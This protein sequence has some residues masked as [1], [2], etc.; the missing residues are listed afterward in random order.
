[1]SPNK[2]ILDTHGDP[3]LSARKAA[4]RLRCASDYVSKL[5][6]EGKLDG[7]LVDGQWFVAPASIKAFEEARIRAKQERSQQLAEQRRKENFEYKK[8]YG[9]FGTRTLLRARA[10]A[11]SAPIG[12]IAGGAM[13][14]GAVVFASTMHTPAH[15]QLASVSSAESAFFGTQPPAVHVSGAAFENAS[16]FLRGTF[17]TLFGSS[18]NNTIELAQNSSPSQRG[19]LSADNSPMSGAVAPANVSTGLNSASAP[20]VQNI[21]NTYPVIQRTVV[22]QVASAGVSED[23]VTLRLQDLYNR[24]AVQ[25]S[26]LQ[27]P[28]RESPLQNFAVSQVIN[29]LS[30]VRLNGLSTADDIN[31]HTIN[32]GSLSI[33]GDASFGGTNN[34]NTV[35][36]A[37][38]LTAATTTTGALTVNGNATTTG[39]AYFQNDVNIGGNTVI[40]G[41]LTVLNN[42][43]NPGTAFAGTTTVTNLGVTNL[44]TSTFAGSLQTGGALAVGGNQ[45]SGFKLSVNGLAYIGDPAAPYPGLVPGDEM[46]AQLV[47]RRDANPATMVLRNMN[48]LTDAADIISFANSSD[49][50]DGKLQLNGVAATSLSGS[51][52]FNIMSNFGDIGFWRNY[53]GAGTPTNSLTIKGASAGT[54][55]GFVGIGTQSPQA[56]LDVRD[57]IFVRNTDGLVG[58]NDGVEI[59]TD[60]SVPRISIV[61][62]NR[63]VGLFGGTASGDVLVQNSA[64]GSTIFKGGSGG[65]VE[66]AR[67]TNDGNFGLGT[68]NPNYKLSI[69][70]GSAPGASFPT[71]GFGFVL[72][73][74]GFANAN[75]RFASVEG[76]KA[77]YFL[78]RDTGVSTG[79]LSTYDYGAGV[80]MP[81]LLNANGGNVSIGSATVAQS[82]LDVFGSLALGSYAGVNAAPTNG[83]IVSG[84]VG[85]GTTTPATTFAV[86]GNGL[87][88]GTFTAGSIIATSSFTL[89]GSG[90]INGGFAAYASSTIGNGNQN[91]GLTIFGG[92]TTTGN[93]LFTGGVGIG[94][95]TSAAGTLQVAN[96]AYFGGNLFVGGNSTTIGNST[97]N[98]LVI[99]SSIKSDLVPDQNITRDLGSPSFYWRNVYV[100][101]IVANNISAAS[102]TISGTNSATFTINAD[103]VTSDTE[104][105]DLIFFRGN[106]VPN[107]LLSW[108][109]T[110]KRFEFN[111]P[112]FIQNNTNNTLGNTTLDLKGETGQTGAL[113]NVASSTGTSYFNIANTG[114]TTLAQGFISQASST[115]NGSL[116]V[117]GSAITNGTI[118]ASNIIATSTLTVNGLAIFSNGISLTSSTTIGN[119]NQNG[120]LTIFGGATTT[121]N[122]LFSGALTAAGNSL[123][124]NATSTNFFS[125]T[126]SSTNLF[127]ANASFGTAAAQYLTTTAGA[128]IDNYITLGKNIFGAGGHGDFDGG[129]RFNDTGTNIPRGI[130]SASNG[131]AMAIGINGNNFGSQ[132]LSNQ[133]VQMYFD[134]RGPY[135]RF[136]VYTYEAGTGA[137]NAPISLSSVNTLNIGDGAPTNSQ[138]A[139]LY[140]KDNTSLASVPTFRIDQNGNGTS[141]LMQWFTSGGVQLGAIKAN[142]NLGIGTSTA[143]QA[144]SVQGNGLFSGNISAAAITATSTLNVTG[145]SSFFNGILATASSTIGNGNQ[146]GGLTINGGATTTGSAY[147]AS[148]VGI[149]TANPGYTLD[150]NGSFHANSMFLTGGGNSLSFGTSNANARITGDNA[151]SA[152]YLDFY[153]EGFSR[154]HISDNGNVGIGTTTPSQLFAV[155][156]NQYTSGTAFFGGAITA[157]STLN[158]TGLS[159][160]GSLS[161]TGN[162]TLANATSTNFFSTVASSTNLFAQTGSIGTL[163]AQALTVSGNTT[164]T[165]TL[166]Q[167]GLATFTNGFVS[168]ASST[169]S[170]GL[171][172]ANGGAS[173]TVLSASGSAYFATSG[174]NVG[175]GQ[176]SPKEKL[177][178]NGAGIFSGD[179]ATGINAENYAAAVLIST[180]SGA[181]TGRISAASNGANNVDLELRALNAGSSNSGQLYL[182]SNGNVGIGT[183]S[184]FYKLSV[185]GS[186]TLGNQAIAGFFNATSTTATSTFSGGLTVGG[187]NFNVTPNGNVG[188]GAATDGSFPFEVSNAGGSFAQ[189]TRSS[190]G[191][192]ILGM[193]GSFGASAGSYHDNGDFQIAGSGTVAGQGLIIQTRNTGNSLINALYLNGSGAVGIGTTTTNVSQSG[194][195]TVNANPSTYLPNAFVVSSTTAAGVTSN[196][197]NVLANGTVGVGTSSPATTL[198]VQG[199]GYFTGNVG[200][201]LSSPTALLEVAGNANSS[202]FRVSRIGNASSYFSIAA[203]GG[204]NNA[205][206]FGVNGTSVLALQLNG[207]IQVGSYVNISNT[208]VAA[209]ANGLIMA[210][211]LGIGTTSPNSALQ[212]AGVGQTTANM[213]DSGVQTA[214][215]NIEDNNASNPAGAGGALVFSSA[216][217]AGTY[218]QA[219]IK[220]LITNGG[221]RG[222][223]DLAFSTRNATSDT[224]LTERLRITAGGN[225]GIGTTSPYATFAVNGNS[226]LGTSATA[227]YFTATSTTATTSINGV[228]T[229]GT[230]S[231][232]TI[233]RNGNQY[234]G[235]SSFFNLSYIGNPLT[236]GSGYHAS[237]FNNSV[238]NRGE[239][240]Q[241]GGAMGS[242]TGVGNFI[243]ALSFVNSNSSGGNP[244]QTATIYGFND[245]AANN[246]AMAFFTQNTS[247]TA[248][249]AMRINSSQQVGIGTTTPAAALDVRGSGGNVGIFEADGTA[250]NP[251]QLQIRGVSNYNKVFQIGYNTTN[252]YGSLQA[253]TVGS[254]FDPIALNPLGGNVG[255]GT[256]TPGSPLTVSGAGLVSTFY[257]TNTSSD[258]PVRML[259]PSL[260]TGNSTSLDIGTAWNSNYNSGQLQFTNAGGTGSQSNYIGLGVWGQT[261]GLIVNGFGNVGIGTTS[262]VATLGMTGSIGVNSTQLS[263]NANGSVGVGTNTTNAKFTINGTG[264]NASHGEL[265]ISNTAVTSNLGIIGIETGNNSLANGGTLGD[266]SIISAGSLILQAGGGGT[267]KFNNT[268][269]GQAQFFGWSQLDTD[270]RSGAIFVGSNSG[271]RGV[272]QYGANPSSSLSIDNTYDS[273]TG[274]GIQFRT[275]TSGTST[276]TAMAILNNGNIGVGTTNPGQKLTVAGADNSATVSIGLFRSSLD[277]GLLLSTVGSTGNSSIVASGS[278]S[279]LTLGASGTSPF[280]IASNGNVGI[281]S[282]SPS[283]IMSIQSAVSTAQMTVAYDTSRYTDFLTN[284]VGDLTITPQGQDIFS[285]DSN[286]W[287]CSGG[288]CPSGTPTGTGN[289]IVENNIGIGT[290]TPKYRLT[291]ESQ[292]NTDNLFQIASS[293]NQSIVVVNANGRVGIGTSTPS[294]QFSVA[295]RLFVGAGGASGMGTATST[296]QGDIK[297]TGKLDVG[298]IDP[299]YTIDGVKYATYGHSTVGL[300]EEAVAV[301]EVTDKNP[302]T[303]KYEKKISFKD[304]DKGSD[305]WL[306]YQVTDFGDN[307]KNLVINLTASFDGSVFYTKVPNE[308][309]VVVS[310]DQP[311]EVSARFIAN[312]FDSDKWPNIRPDQNGPYKGHELQTTPTGQAT[313]V[314]SIMPIRAD[315][316][317][318]AQ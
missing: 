26:N 19:E 104:D 215:L 193:T 230:G 168:Q 185:E 131:T 284:S 176:N 217:T 241:L 116:T 94:V 291:I 89:N 156:G 219:A 315:A 6:R 99:N 191:T 36:I 253:Q 292:N 73:G 45:Y 62:G 135:G 211:S 274:I 271:F 150:V 155:Q 227:G 28:G 264:G 22:Q 132:A 157:T 58:T 170:G 90:T 158:V 199:N 302:K 159:T 181:T 248:T 1:M 178:S 117:N 180:N 222:I 27:N 97:S 249:E 258:Q 254:T 288:S 301:L 237:V 316:F 312:R 79:E 66:L 2:K 171:F 165:G 190:V 112:L 53:S 147:F 220:A 4:L 268:S 306:F 299:V 59:A 139:T 183:T 51:R 256:T 14:F 246:G 166:T 272:I 41:N 60:S 196:L 265:E 83:F 29:N 115:V 106:V 275:R 307:W 122:A 149:G 30:N 262:P 203:T 24:I 20:V 105:Q 47:I 10:L 3:M 12:A 123:F 119:G 35:H 38:I 48:A 31:A 108:K 127:A 206:V 201:G 93:A 297:I 221:G 205:S 182:K 282:T 228:L 7:Q 37:G 308:A 34:F 224:N 151:S 11:V 46:E 279:S 238:G 56:K 214:T 295:D 243:G 202:D 148:N 197:F 40:A 280:V 242:N 23:Y 136:D 138:V 137:E 233:F 77:T 152:N 212:I 293:T 144:L 8:T 169:V 142:G 50:Q 75:N 107:A 92:A 54:T 85:I 208:L 240:L 303:G 32:S 252:S 172:T 305:L 234:I 294:Q 247:G 160:L 68:A 175:I 239:V 70:N 223:G 218:A 179:F 126:A 259:Q 263:I 65:N 42:N 109:T 266:L 128:N 18:K 277:Y 133:G 44:S 154:L 310:A 235:A 194:L 129:I 113:F 313:A 314:G 84:N 162:T 134:A 207:G 33:T 76:N 111:Q 173:T 204:N 236:E 145:L 55:A 98:S 245:T 188:I 267:V 153:T 16:N 281:G 43:G 74:T 231:T 71:S 304:L 120:G 273:S 216:A 276:T 286:L 232:Q 226:D 87:V 186:S 289:I 86:Q 57:Q 163:N 278:G 39:V 17:A 213:T 64:G 101:N 49:D 300:K 124:S 195:L 15:S 125:T 283:R 63:Y 270:P 317:D 200:V 192:W 69:E 143:S 100:G 290:T 61:A 298:T 257:N 118:T 52:S 174:G 140:V 287:I 80:G 21:T 261:N 82:T 250:T 244:G 13:L 96:N 103:N 141:D 121:G 9:S 78:T 260:S 81:L 311:G 269:T 67:I 285:N 225:I 91:G 161:V 251:T 130:T 209:P 114:L 164:H 189:F 177:D 296:F 309:A 102:T 255:I 198:S 184:P 167:T 229:Q 210:G 88:S 146:N 110:P 72:S 318:P 25:L 187:S 95:A 5:C